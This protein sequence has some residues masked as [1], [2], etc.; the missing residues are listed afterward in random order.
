MELKEVKS[1]TL[2]SLFLR[3][4]L[5]LTAEFFIEILLFILLLYFGIGFNFILPADYSENYLK[6]NKAVIAK[7]EPFDKTLIPNTCT[8]GVFDLE[9][10]YLYGD[11]EDTVVADAKVFLKVSKSEKHRFFLI[12]K[13]KESIVINYDISAHFA[14]STLN[15]IFPKLE[16]LLLSLFVFI[17]I[18]I[19]IHC[20][21]SFDRSLNKELKPLLDEINQIQN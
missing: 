10:N 4:L 13:A 14:S 15:S 8:Y 11:F 20:A 9:G 17:F 1:R 2:F 6:Q 7:S 16:L 18:L 12:E 5:R 19:V 3:Q 21:L